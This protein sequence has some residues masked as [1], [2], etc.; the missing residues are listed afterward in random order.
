MTGSAPQLYLTLPHRQPPV[1]SRDA[2]LMLKSRYST[3]AARRLHYTPGP[4]LA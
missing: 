1:I 4:I 3:R 2:A